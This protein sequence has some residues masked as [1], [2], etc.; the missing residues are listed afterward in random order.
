MPRLLSLLLVLA[1][2]APAAAAEGEGYETPLAEPVRVLVLP[3]EPIDVKADTA[4]VITELVTDTYAQI[5]DFNVVSAD[6]IKRLVELEGDRAQ[7][8][9]DTNSASC[10]AELAGALGARY[11]VFGTVGRLGELTIINLHL[12][13]ADNA[14]S[15]QRHVIRTTEIETLPE[16]LEQVVLGR[17]APVPDDVPEKDDGA[18][19][20]LR[21]GGISAA[22]AGLVG[23]GASVVGLFM[24]ETTLAS[25]SS[26]PS[27]KETALV[28]YPFV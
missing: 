6:E 9:C 18:A 24:V 12:F 1:S 13:D 15:M 8:G 19:W 23:L 25:P 17:A 2:A 20:M 10:L 11:V 28:A 21:M 26:P 14:E 4:R 3:L 16:K 22:T 27:D 7:A 5:P